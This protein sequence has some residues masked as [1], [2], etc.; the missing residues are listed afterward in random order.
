MGWIPNALSE[1]RDQTHI[2]MDTSWVHEPLSHMRIS[3]NFYQLFALSCHHPATLF[4]FPP[5]PSTLFLQGFQ[6]L[7]LK[8][9]EF[10]G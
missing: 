8:L 4:L 10:S 5:L 9:L 3:V 1:A 6:T 2:L 7:V